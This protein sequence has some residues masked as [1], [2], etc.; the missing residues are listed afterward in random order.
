[1]QFTSVAEAVELAWHVREGL[2]GLVGK[3]RPPGS[4]LIIEDVCFPQ[5]SLAEGVHDLQALL[6]TH[7]FVPGVA[8]HA[9]HGNLHFTLVAELNHEEGKKR[10]SA[11]MRELIDLVVGKHDGSLKAEHG[12]GINM[13]P[14]V[15]DEWGEKATR[16]MWRIKELADPLGVL[17][18]NVILTR[19]SAVH[20][21][22][23]KSVPGIEGISNATQCIECGFCEPVCP[24]RNVTTTPRQRIALRREMARQPEHS[25]VLRRLQE[26]YE[27]DAIE[28]CAGD[29]TCSLSC[30]IG[31]NTGALMREFRKRGHGDTSEAIALRVAKNWA[32]VERYARAGLAVSAI[33]QRVAGPAPAEI[34]TAIARSII[35]RDLIPSVP[36]LMPKPAGKP[37]ITSSQDAAAVYFP[38]CINRM[39]GRDPKSDDDPSLFEA[40]IRISERA[41]CPLWIPPDVAGLCCSTPFSSKGYEQAHRY[42]ASTIAEALWRWSDRGRL[43]VVVDAAS[44]TLGLME[45]VGKQLDAS[46]RERYKTI[47]I[48]DSIEW[49]RRLLPRL[50]IRRALG[51]VVLHP[52]CSMTHLK[53]TEGLEEIAKTL[54]LTVEIPIGAACCGMAG[55]RGLLHPELV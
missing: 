48:M 4:M 13:A 40:L 5:T 38:A 30:P 18:P 15:S 21:E 28:T 8:G 19:N 41:G 37:P 7:G 14:F 49:C 29:G 32:A 25:V 43:P 16:M 55:D 46:I 54:A 6:Q 42:M 22:G 3:A 1:V 33:A 44:C 36:G 23:L 53:L 20:L 34:V 2:L 24:S 12:T 51:H 31:I 45:D 26:D 11:F 9:A 52:T 50:H 17:G 10:Y 39:F 47:R 27:Y 35:S